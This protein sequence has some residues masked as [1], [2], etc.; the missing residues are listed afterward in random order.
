MAASYSN[1]F[2]MNV[3]DFE[4]AWKQFF[5]KSRQKIDKATEEAAKELEAYMKAKAPWQDRTGAARRNLKAT[6]ENTAFKHT[7]TLSQNVPYGIYLEL[8]MGK[9]F[10]IIDPTLKSKGAEV[11]KKLSKVLSS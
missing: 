6:A 4:K 7:I 10:A 2:S 9:R 5:K 3:T 11:M 8:G 1:C